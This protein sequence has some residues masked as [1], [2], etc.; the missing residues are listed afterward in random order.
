MLPSRYHPFVLMTTVTAALSLRR[1]I[2]FAA[3]GTPLGFVSLLCFGRPFPLQGAS[4]L[5]TVQSYREGGGG[6]RTGA[7]KGGV[8][9]D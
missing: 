7:E 8:E 4:Q 9:D 1:G 5:Q 2:L 3:S 6:A